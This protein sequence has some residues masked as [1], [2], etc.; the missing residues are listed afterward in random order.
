[1]ATTAPLPSDSKSRRRNS[2][3]GNM[4]NLST[5][6]DQLEN[7]IWQLRKVMILKLQ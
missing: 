3:R 6:Y 1:M 5:Q 7:M 4:K 2:G